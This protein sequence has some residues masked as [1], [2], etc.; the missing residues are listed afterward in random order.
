MA[1]ELADTQGHISGF[2]CR[3]HPALQCRDTRMRAALTAEKQVV[4]TLWKREMPDCYWSVG[5]HSG[6]GKS[7]V[8]ASV[9]Q[10]FRAINHLLLLRTVTLLGN[11][12]FTGDRFAATGFTNCDG[13]IDSMHVAVLAPGHLRVHQQKG[14][15][16]YGYSSIGGILLPHQHWLVREDV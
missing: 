12:Q 2:V 3:A 1:V 10:V 4:I 16:F 15:P 13:S 5:N 14:L 9:L 7:T 8:E 11:V 6:A